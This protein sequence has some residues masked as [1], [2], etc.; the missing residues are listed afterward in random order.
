[1]QFIQAFY[2]PSAAP[3]FVPKFNAVQINGAFA[4]TGAAPLGAGS[5]GETWRIA[6]GSDVVAAKVITSP[7]YPLDYL[8]R[9]I[10]GLRSCDSPYIVRL[11][12]DRMVQLNGD[13]LPALVFEFIDGGDVASH[14]AVG[15]RPDADQLREFARG[16]LVAISLLHGCNTVHRDI[17]P[18]N[19]ALRGGDWT[20]PVL[21]DLG[22]AKVLD[23][24]TITQYPAVMGTVPFMAPEQLQGNPARQMADMFA[25]GAVLYLLHTGKHPYYGPKAQWIDGAAATQRIDAGPP[26]LPASTPTD[27]ATVVNRLLHPKAHRRGRAE[28]ALDDLN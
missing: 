27:L 11:I 7:T 5:F 16:L 22:L 28:R 25:I 18:E 13:Y 17:K 8:M 24:Q 26:A 19:I 4:A 9:E 2:E 6:L 14:L 21:L 3:P 20:Q 23:Q 15:S 10:D 12:D 1:M